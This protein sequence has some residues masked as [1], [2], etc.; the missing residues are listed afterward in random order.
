VAPGVITGPLLGSVSHLCFG[1]HR[2]FRAI[3]A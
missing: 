3:I 1:V 2:P